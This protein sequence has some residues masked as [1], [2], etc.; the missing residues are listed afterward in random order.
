MDTGDAVEVARE[1]TIQ[2]LCHHYA[3]DRLSVEELDALLSRA[4]RAGD[5]RELDALLVGLP[6][7]STAPAR[8]G[9]GGVV[10]HLGASGPLDRRR[11]ERIATIMGETK[12]TGAW[13]VPPRL[14]VIAVMGDVKLDL[15]E[16]RLGPHTVIDAT[17]VMAE[18]RV[19]VPPGV[20]LETAGGSVMGSFTERWGV[21]DTLPS[22][23]PIV[24]VTGLSVMADVSV[25]VGAPGERKRKK[26][27]GG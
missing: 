16:A 25:K 9:D 5:R 17:A 11:E 6:E 23:A 15:T 12:R 20:R 2:A 21:D 10:A 7:I 19:L 14:R 18:V 8:V 4:Q 22:D 13:V 27:F 3:H 1:R 26:L 24:R